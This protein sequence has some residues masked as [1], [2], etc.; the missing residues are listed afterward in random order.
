MVSI[1]RQLL[2]L[3][4]AFLSGLV[5]LFG[6]MLLSH[7]AYSNGAAW[8]PG[9]ISGTPGPIK[10]ND[11]ILQKE[12]VIFDDSPNKEEGTVTAE[13]WIYNP[14]NKEITVTMGFP[15]D[16]SERATASGW[17]IK[18]KNSERYTIK[19][20]GIGGEGT[21]ASPEEDE[22]SKYIEDFK[23]KFDVSVDGNKVTATSSGKGTGVYN[24]VYTWDMTFPPMK[25]TQYTVKY[26]MTVSDK[27]QD[28]GEGDSDG[29]S[30]GSHSFTYITHTG[31]YWA[32]PIGDATF[33]YCS[34]KL[35]KFIL[36]APTG[37]I[38]EVRETALTYDS[39]TEGWSIKPKPYDINNEKGCIV[40]RRQ[41]WLP[42]K[43]DD[44]IQVST[45][46]KTIGYQKTPSV[47][48]EVHQDALMKKWCGASVDGIKN[49]HFGQD[50][51][52]Q[53]RELSTKTYNAIAK[54]AYTYPL[55]ND[56]KNFT[57]EFHGLSVQTQTNYHLLL[58]RY[59][60][61]YIFAVHGH[62]FK[63][64]KLAQCFQSVN[65]VT[66]QNLTAIEK[67]NIDWLS[68]YEKQMKKQNQG[69]SSASKNTD[70]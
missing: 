48:N 21:G 45:Y 54:K 3:K 19:S 33:E 9:N 25:T 68:D 36:S 46:I 55:F 61:N 24:T 44:D 66:S 59:L 12:Y 37:E 11:L 70:E 29:G 14:T 23:D 53:E 26:P 65:K 41:N 38:S 1:S 51:N 31:A 49:Y 57:K 62:V 20:I 52:V 18:E 67:K 60:R 43:Y 40:W 35:I 2:S 22:R 17:P 39:H 30:E 50:A 4:T 27:G 34:E 13:F 47:E 63:D 8:N 7:N 6:T 10:Q 16:Y 56:D 32:K 42:K 28:H 15:L 64:Q 58:L 69:A 5:L